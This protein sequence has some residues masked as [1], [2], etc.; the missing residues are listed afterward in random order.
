LYKNVSVLDTGARG[1][2]VSFVERG[3]GDVF[4][5]W[6][7]EA[8]LLTHQLAKDQFD[9]VTP[10]VSILAERPVPIVDRVV[11]KRGTR[12]LAQS[13]LEFLS[14]ETGQ[15]IAGKHFYR[16]RLASAAAKHAQQF[17]PVSM[18]TIEEVFGG[19]RNAPKTH[20]SEGGVFDQI[21]QSNW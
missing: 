11:D 16:P 15:E 6:E 18:F 4:I 20:F 8:L 13:Y 3:I 10:S 2:T 19:R 12:E 1:S 9:I 5:P 7:N 14:G 21:Y 17:Q